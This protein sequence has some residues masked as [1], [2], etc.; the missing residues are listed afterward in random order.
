MAKRSLMFV[1]AHPDD[2]TFGPGGTIAR[3]ARDGVRIT[4]ITATSGQAGRTAGLASTPEELGRVREQEAR[5]AAASLGIAAIHFFGY[6]DGRLDQVDEE[7][8][9]EKVVRRIREEQPD[10]VV[11]FGPEG[12]GNEHRDHQRISRIATEAVASTADPEKFK[13]QLTEGLT[14]HLVSKFYYMTGYS[15]PWGEMRQ[16]FLPVTTVIDIADFV[17]AKIAA[18]RLH[19]SQQQWMTKLQE[20]IE[21]NRHQEVYYRASSVVANL[22]ELE[23]DLFTGLP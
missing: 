8:V 23:T 22:P 7:E 1:L 21:A 14:P 3:Y 17:E 4:V 5:D 11:T 19:R 9:E 16:A 18:F 6:M 2:E 13:A 15:N 20:W 12:A 10:V